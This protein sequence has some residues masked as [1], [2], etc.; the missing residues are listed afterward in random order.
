MLKRINLGEMQCEQ[1]TIRFHVTVSPDVRDRLLTYSHHHRERRVPDLASYGTVY[2]IG[3]SPH[4]VRG[5][6]RRVGDAECHIDIEYTQRGMP[7]PPRS[8]RSVQSLLSMLP[9]QKEQTNLYLNAYFSYGDEWVSP[10]E[11]PNPISSTS[12][13]LGFTAIEAVRISNRTDLARQFAI[14]FSRRSN[15]ELR[16]WVSMIIRGVWYP[17]L[18]QVFLDIAKTMSTSFVR[19]KE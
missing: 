7:K 14:E 2:E 13:G 9:A 15:G 10:I 16:H 6:V 18:P 19:H 1:L 11:I 4:A 5:D 3:G 8:F 17:D 12:E